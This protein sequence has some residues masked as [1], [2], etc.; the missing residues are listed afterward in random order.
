MMY[1]M[2]SADGR[3]IGP[4]E[5]RELVSYGLTRDSLVWRK[6][7]SE[8]VPASR[9]PELNSLLS[10]IPPEPQDS[11]EPPA[12]PSGSNN[13]QQTNRPPQSG[14][15]FVNQS[16][17]QQQCG[18]MTR[19]DNYMVWSILATVLC[20]LPLGIVS[21]VYSGKVNDYWEQGRSVEAKEASDKAK[22]WAMI[23][24]GGGLLSS[25]IGFFMLIAFS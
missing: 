3:R 24:A 18:N 11:E 8:W 13:Y 2:M 12:P 9:V 19:P 6:D 14:A 7:F 15:P 22:M 1:Y 4:V 25:M 21:I 10:S 17:S 16:F 23:A 5:A 20:C